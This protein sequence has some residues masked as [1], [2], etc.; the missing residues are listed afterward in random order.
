MSFLRLVPMGSWST[1]FNRA[2]NTCASSLLREVGPRTSINFKK[3]M[4]LEKLYS[5]EY[6]VQYTQASLLGLGPKESSHIPFAVFGQ[7][8]LP[9]QGNEACYMDMSEWNKFIIAIKDNCKTKEQREGFISNFHK[10]G[11]K[12]VELSKELGEKECDNNK[13]ITSSYQ[14]YLEI[15]NTYT[16]YIW[17][18]HFLN[19]EV[20]KDGQEILKGKEGGESLYRPNKKTGIV[21]L[22]AD[23]H[24]IRNQNNKKLEESEIEKLLEKYGWMSCLDIMNDPWGESDLLEMYNSLSTPE[25]VVTIN[26]IAKQLNLSTEEKEFFGVV[27]EF[28]FINDMRDVYRRKGICNILPFFEKIGKTIGVERKDLA[29]FTNEE[30][31]KALETNEVPDKEEIEKRKQGFQIYWEDKDIVVTSDVDEMKMFIEKNIKDSEE[32]EEL[33]GVVA[34]IGVAEGK[35]VIVRGV[36]DLDKVKEGD[37]LVAITTH[38][39]FVPAMQRASAIVTDEGGITSHAAIVSREMKKPCI[40]NTKNATKVLQDGQTISVDAN[41]GILI[42]K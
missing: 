32:S 3:Y 34:S 13:E 12:Y 38:P 25:Q 9:E 41:K 8:Y 26:E 14:S 6:S 31:I 39:N 18:G 42:I 11:K 29:Y 33:S 24:K 19:K 16:A 4:K 10:Y 35:V 27:R 30:I 22:Q 40:V 5:R 20:A 2:R 36:A 1:T 37:V 28:A 17:L 15:L 23:L 7:T 21:E